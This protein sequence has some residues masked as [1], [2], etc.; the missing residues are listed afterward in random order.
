MMSVRVCV[1]YNQCR[2]KGNVICNEHW[3]KEHTV[4]YQLQQA[5]K[6]K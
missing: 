1:E 5:R 4:I 6:E 3:T 2:C